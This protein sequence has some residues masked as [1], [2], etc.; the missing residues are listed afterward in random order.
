MDEHEV[1]FNTSKNVSDDDCISNVSNDDFSTRGDVF[2][3]LTKKVLPE[4][5]SKS[6]INIETIGRTRYESFVVEKL[7]G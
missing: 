3:V 6:F 2:N 1:A 4:N 5:I 7:E